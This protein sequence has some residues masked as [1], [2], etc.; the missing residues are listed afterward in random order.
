[1]KS[2]LVT[3][4]DRGSALAIIRALD[5]RGWRVIAGSADPLSPGF[6][7]R[8]TSARVRYPSPVTD[9][10]RF[11]ARI[12]QIVREKEI[13]LIIPVTEEV[14]LHLDRERNSFDGLCR[15][16]V[17]DPIK[18]DITRDKARTMDLARCVDVP[19]PQTFLVETEEEAVVRA[20]A[21]RWPIVLKPTLSRSFDS[22]VG[23]IDK[24]SVSYA[25]DLDA[26]REQ[27]RA[28]EGRSPVLLQEYYPGVGHGV[29]LLAWQ[30]QILAAFQHRRICEIPVQGGA[31][32]LRQSVDLDPQLYEYARRL[33]ESMEWTGLLMIEFKVGEQGAMLMEINGRVWGSLPL[34]LESGMDFP[35][36]LAA[37]YEQPPSNL[38]DNPNTDYHLDVQ[39]ANIEMLLLWLL[40]VLFGKRTYDFLPFPA[41]R[42]L[43]PVIGKMLTLRLR[44]DV[45][46]L[47]DPAPGAL[48]PLLLFR[49]SFRKIKMLL[50]KG[51]VRNEIE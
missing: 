8:H 17:A 18:L 14:I 19:I 6:Y 22:R 7:S 11:I 36:R 3:D 40:Q 51:G 45:L 1:M 24:L 16:A 44:Y 20:P 33:T 2:V 49:K 39:T 38:I 10:N 23:K 48:I 30:G 26:L 47:R 35:G 37:L 27:M 46:S 50:F 21:L 15:L 5:R 4:A 42:E 9:G 13:D 32:A 43:F 29:E 31:S 12:L 25:N 34:A 28:Y 41:R